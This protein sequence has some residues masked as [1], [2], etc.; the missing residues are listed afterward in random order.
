MELFSLLSFLLRYLWR[1]NLIFAFCLFLLQGISCV[2]SAQTRHSSYF[3]KAQ[4]Y[5]T[6]ALYNPL[7]LLINGGY[8][9]LQL[10]SHEDAR[11]IINLPYRQ[12]GENV[13]ETVG[14]PVRTLNKFGWRRFLTTEIIPTS[15]D[16]NKSQYVPNYFLHLLGGGMHFRATEEWYRYHGFVHPRLLSLATMVAYHVLSEVVE[17]KG[18]QNLTVDHLAD[19][20]VFD[21]LGIWLFS[22][23]SVCKFFSQ[24]FQLAEWSMQPAY[25]LTNGHLENMG[26]FYVLKY[27]IIKDG[28]WNF[29]IH[30]GLHGMAG[31]SQR[32]PDGKSF[33]LTGGFMV[34]K[35][36]RAKQEGEGRALTAVLTWMVGGFYD[37]NNSLL[38]SLMLSGLPESRLRFNIYPG[39]L[40]LG[41]LRPGIFFS[42]SKEWVAGLNVSYIPLGAA[43]SL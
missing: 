33:S 7:A 5:G 40:K 25:N 15:L 1:K 6:Q 34:E 31:I 12:W 16:I 28:S 2:S 19:L 4:P 30:L 23:D 32:K 43:R 20:Y 21:P 24:K 29:M 8:G 22:F 13:W 38:A 11:E 18:S 42:G 10:A 41:P 9:I 36:V 14:H 27:P 37:L 39:F 3:Y 35:L 17:N 26:Q